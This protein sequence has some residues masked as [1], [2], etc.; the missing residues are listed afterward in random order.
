MSCPCNWVY[1]VHIYQIPNQQQWDEE[2]T[3]SIL[4]RLFQS[5]LYHPAQFSFYGP[6]KCTLT[7]DPTLVVN[8]NPCL[9][10]L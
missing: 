10:F 9:L 3:H 7:Y 1:C 5:L 2:A 6:G 4:T 8:I